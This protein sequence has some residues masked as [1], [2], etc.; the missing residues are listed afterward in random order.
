ML[1]L[2]N[3]RRSLISDKMLTREINF[4]ALLKGGGGGGGGGEEG[5]DGKLLQ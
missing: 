1:G 3:V 2:P 5:G 4:R